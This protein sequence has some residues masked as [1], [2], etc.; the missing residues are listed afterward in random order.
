MPNYVPLRPLSDPFR[1]D[2]TCCISTEGGWRKKKSACLKNN[3]VN[4]N[5]FTIFVAFC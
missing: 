1:R 5:L 4:I 2:A 3:F